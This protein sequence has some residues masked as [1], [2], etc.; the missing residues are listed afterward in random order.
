METKNFRDM[1]RTELNEAFNVWIDKE[2]ANGL[3]DVKF[4]V[5]SGTTED[6]MKQLL[7]IQEMEEKGETRTY[8]DY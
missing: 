1:N 2:K 5:E 4:C 7:H 8:S 3:V 6:A